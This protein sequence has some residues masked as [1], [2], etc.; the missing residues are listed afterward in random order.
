MRKILLLLF[1]FCSAM[2]MGQGSSM[3]KNTIPVIRILDL[4]RWFNNA[5]YPTPFVAIPGYTNISARYKWIAGAFDSA[6]HVGLWNGVPTG[7]RTGVWQA[8]GEIAMD[9]TTGYFY[10]RQGGVW[11]KYAKYSDIGSGNF[12]DSIWRVVGKDSIFY[13]KNGTTYKIKDSTGLSK[14]FGVDDNSISFPRDVTV[15]GSGSF[16]WNGLPARNDTSQFYLMTLDRIGNVMGYYPYG[17]TGGGGVSIIDITYNNLVVAIDDATLTPGAIY[18]IT[19]RGDRGLFFTAV[20][21]NELAKNGTRLMLCPSDYAIETD[22]HGNVWKGIWASYKTAS[23]NNLMIWGGKVYKNLTG[24]IGTATNDTLLDVTNWVA[25]SKSGFTNYEYTEMSFGVNFDIANDWIEKQWDGKGNVITEPY[26]WSQNYYGRFVGNGCS[27]T[28]WNLGSEFYN[29]TAMAVF[30][31][32]DIYAIYNNICKSNAISNNVS[33]P[34]AESPVSIYRN[35]C[36][37]GIIGNYIR[38]NIYDNLVYQIARNKVNDINDNVVTAVIADDTVTNIRANY[39]SKSIGSVY[40]PSYS[41]IGCFTNKD[42]TGAISANYTELTIENLLAGVGTKQVRYNP[43]T[44]NFTY[45]DTTGG[46]SS[47]IDDVL[48]VGQTLTADRGIDADG[49]DLTVSSAGEFGVGADTITFVSNVSGGAA[50]WITDTVRVNK[51]I[52]YT[53]NLNSTLTDY[54]LVTK[55]YVDSVS[56]G[57]F[58]FGI[59]DSIGNERKFHM[60]GNNFTIYNESDAANILLSTS[61]PDTAYGARLYLDGGDSSF[62]LRN[63]AVGIRSNAAGNKL[64]LLLNA[65]SSDTTV[66]KP[67]GRSSDGTTVQMNNWPVGTGGAISDSSKFTLQRDTIALASFGAG[68]SNAG[69][70]T[71]FTTSTIYGSFYN[72]GSDT[73]VITSIRA[74]LQGSSPSLVPTV[75]YNDSINVTA[76]AT[77]LVNSPSALTNTAV[78]VSS[79]PDNKKIPP[80]VWVWVK[81]ETVTTKPTYFSLTLIGYKKRK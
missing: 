37:D 5:G 49:F 66:Y 79:T 51:R 30:N 73:L 80:G 9:T 77:K 31:N 36:V 10:G 72:D 81:T 16:A 26:H 63:N 48:A 52:S 50:M 69:D 42:I 39:V 29:N 25:I 53:S 41:V 8:D 78:G 11:I 7:V 18:K 19:D 44:G 55:R 71:S 1:I 27:I 21:V 2:A 3:P 54:S 28:D 4:S 45:T 12:V 32:A 17:S 64:Q 38:G 35:I 46:G 20:S 6:L 22:A 61:R 13:S 47:G 33:N 40:G 23:V 68:G 67:L 34:S 76:G 57:L 58:R 65:T 24:S 59:E 60:N 43:S 14:R 75:Y 56:G 62:Q 74:V 15:S 70:T